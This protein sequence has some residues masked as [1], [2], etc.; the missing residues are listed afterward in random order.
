MSI[1]FR[2]ERISCAL[3]ICHFCFFLMVPAVMQHMSL[4]LPGGQA[5]PFPTYIL[6]SH[7]TFIPWCLLMQIHDWACVPPFSPAHISDELCI[8]RMPSRWLSKRTANSPASHLSIKLAEFCLTLDRTVGAG[9][10]YANLAYAC[11]CFH[12]MKSAKVSGVS[13]C[14]ADLVEAKLVGI[15]DIL[16]E[17]NRFPQASDQ[18]F[19][20]E[21]HSKHKDHFR[22]SV[23][24]SLVFSALIK[25]SWYFCV[26][27]LKKKS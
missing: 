24:H 17:E 26:S 27:N 10:E 8:R 15:L 22:L 13:G 23:S 16:D 12:F 11:A 3:F 14:F 4:R 21:V 2:R 5:G 20:G 9:I 18:H 1:L 19:A 7:L 6:I 25:M